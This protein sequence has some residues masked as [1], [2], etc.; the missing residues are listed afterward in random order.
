VDTP[1]TNPAFSQDPIELAGLFEGDIMLSSQQTQG[2][3]PEIRNN[4]SGSV[5]ADSSEDPEDN[6]KNAIIRESQKW[7]GGVIP[8]FIA[9]QFGKLHLGENGTF[10]VIYAV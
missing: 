6:T 5:D 9:A 10:K 7:P 8:Y 1:A 2:N 3:L 4:I